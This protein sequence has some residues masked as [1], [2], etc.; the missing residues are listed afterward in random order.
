MLI[1]INIVSYYLFPTE[2]PQHKQLSLSPFKISVK[3]TFIVVAVLNVSVMVTYAVVWRR[4]F[5][6]AYL[7]TYCFFSI[8][9]I[10]IATAHPVFIHLPPFIRIN[11]SMGHIFRT[12]SGCA[13]G[14][15][16]AMP[17]NLI[18]LLLLLLL[19]L[20]FISLVTNFSYLCLDVYLNF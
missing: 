12:S 7:F 19:L 17:Y 13:H 15:S 4:R 8:P 5:A 2:G 9:P 11:Q 20:Y 16:D 3:I 6:L 18:I 1:N 10:S 14:A